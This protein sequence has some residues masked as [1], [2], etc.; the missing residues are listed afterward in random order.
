[1]TPVVHVDGAA[2]HGVDA[3][4]R[5]HSMLAQFKETLMK[6]TPLLIAAVAC[7]F[8]TLA[9]LAVLASPE[10]DAV[11]S[12]PPLVI[13]DSSIKSSIKAQFASDSYKG[14]S[15]IDVDVDHHGIV[16]LEGKVPSQDAADRAISIARAT[17]G[18]REVKSDLK[19]KID[20]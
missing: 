17:E 10:S 6:K 1:V 15:H 18:V 4:L 19:V 11:N 3:R 13:K 8:A 16:S 5:G 2:A 12:Q 20:N 7:S 9:P 14:L